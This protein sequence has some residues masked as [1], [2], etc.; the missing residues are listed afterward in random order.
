MRGLAAFVIAFAA[1]SG[2]AGAQAPASSEP[3]AAGRYCIFNNARYSEG[4]MLCSMKEVALECVREE[5]RLRWMP[6]TDNR[7]ASTPSTRPE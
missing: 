4:A 3:A 7:C 1:L 2:S 5:G 6:A